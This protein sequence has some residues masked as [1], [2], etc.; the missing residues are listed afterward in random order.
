MT[1]EKHFTGTTR[2]DVLGF[3]AASVGAVM[4]GTAQAGGIPAAP[5]IPIRFDDPIWNRETAARL[6]A[7]T[8]GRQVYGRCSGI[9]TGVRPGEAVKPIL[10]QKAHPCENVR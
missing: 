6:Q 10:G 8:T 3:A 7:D 9:V 1:D 4:T 5:K 2:R